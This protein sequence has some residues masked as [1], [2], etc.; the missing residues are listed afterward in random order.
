ME[1]SQAA[2]C[3]DTQSGVIPGY[4]ED[5]PWHF[6]NAIAVPRSTQTGFRERPFHPGSVSV[7]CF[8]PEAATQGG[9]TMLLY[10]E[11]CGNMV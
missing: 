9:G 1:A 4:R 2:A 3:P 10:V 8:R 5:L 11:L 6:N 7:P